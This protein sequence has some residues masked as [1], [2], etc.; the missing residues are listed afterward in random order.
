MVKR[1]DPFKD[2]AHLS[3]MMNRLLDDE[4]HHR[5]GAGTTVQSDWT[6]SIDL[7]ELEDQFILKADVAGID[8]KDITVEVVESQLILKGE[9]KLKK[10]G[11][12]EKYFR[13]E[14]PYG[15]FCRI[16]SLPDGVDCAKVHAVLND[17]VLEVVLPKDEKHP[18]RKIAIRCEVD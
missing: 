13:L 10:A 2:I 9:R 14:R 6:P 4:I 5:L 11:Q 12:E 8:R 3:E 7:V 18:D 1:W 17:G 16:F 15:K